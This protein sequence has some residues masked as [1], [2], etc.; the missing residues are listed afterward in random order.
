MNNKEGWEVEFDNKFDV[1]MGENQE[2][3]KDYISKLI[4]LAKA[5]ERKRIVEIIDL[6]L[7]TKSGGTFLALKEIKNKID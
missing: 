6:Y 2:Y 1:Q 7:E 4:T 3:V 5:E